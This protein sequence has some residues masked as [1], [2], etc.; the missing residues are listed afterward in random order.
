MTEA[1]TREL[2]EKELADNQAQ[3]ETHRAAIHALSE[4]GSV[5]RDE[6]AR[7]TQGWAVVAEYD[8]TNGELGNHSQI[9]ALGTEQRVE[10]RNGAIMRLR[11]DY[12][13]YIEG[14]GDE[15]LLEASDVRADGCLPRNPGYT[16]YG[17]AALHTVLDADGKPLTSF[18]I[19]FHRT[20][21]E[22]EE[23][24]CAPGSLPAAAEQPT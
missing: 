3:M 21:E 18:Y 1:R 9:Y 23:A 4:R 11:L 15:P 2:I 22:A 24:T 14:R 12:N 5:L 17:T 7:L 16:A 20:R 10:G 19:T 8:G 13:T 6:L